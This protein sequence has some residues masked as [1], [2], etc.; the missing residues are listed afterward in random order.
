MCFF[1][2]LIPATIWVVLG[3]FILFSSTK[4]QGTL[5]RFGY[6]LA[7]WTFIIAAV[8]PVM[9]AYVTLTGLCPSM[10]TMIKSMQPRALRPATKN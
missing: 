5:Q 7:I 9:G 6:F 4:V 1:L 10:E 3:Y 2:S 8:I